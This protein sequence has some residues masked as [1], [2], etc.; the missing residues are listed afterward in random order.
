MSEA[1]DTQRILE[2][3]KP[4]PSKPAPKVRLPG[5][6]NSGGDSGSGPSDKNIRRE[7]TRGA[8]DKKPKDDRKGKGANDKQGG[9][10]QDKA[11][12]KDRKEK[13]GRNDRKPQAAAEPAKPVPKQEPKQAEPARPVGP[14]V[15]MWA[16]KGAPKIVAAPVEVVKISAAQLNER[17]QATEA[18]VQEPK[19]AKP[20]RT[21]SPKKERGSRNKDKDGKGK[22]G[23]PAKADAPTPT[24]ATGKAVAPAPAVSTATTAALPRPAADANIAAPVPAQPEAAAVNPSLV[25]AQVVSS[26]PVATDSVVPQ[27]VQP[28]VPN[29]SSPANPDDAS[30]LGLQADSIRNIWGSEGAAN[31][32]VKAAFEGGAA[33]LD[34][35]FASAGD[36]WKPSTGGVSGVVLGDPAAARFA[37]NPDG[38]QN[39][40]SELASSGFPGGAQRTI[41][42]PVP[43]QQHFMQPGVPVSRA[44]AYAQPLPYHGMR[45]MSAP[46]AQVMMRPNPA[47][48]MGQMFPPQFVQPGRVAYSVPASGSPYTQPFAPQPAVVLTGQDQK[49]SFVVHNTQNLIAQGQK[50][51]PGQPHYAPMPGGNPMMMG[52][53]LQDKELSADAPTFTMG[54]RADGDGSDAFGGQDSAANRMLARQSAVGQPGKQNF[55]HMQ[56][57]QSQM[58][59]PHGLQQQFMAQRNLFSQSGAPPQFVAS[60]MFMPPTQE[61]PGFPPQFAQ[62]QQFTSL[63]SS[64]SSAQQLPPSQIIGHDQFSHSR[65]PPQAGATLQMPRSIPQQSMADNVIGG[66][67]MPAPADTG[68]APLD[69]GSAPQPKA[70]D[71][72]SMSG[73][74]LAS[75]AL[76]SAASLPEGV[77]FSSLPGGPL[78]VGGSAPGAS[79]DKA[80]GKPGKGGNK[81]TDGS[82]RA[83]GREVEGE[84][85]PDA[86]KDDA[87]KAGPTRSA[88]N[89]RENTTSR[90]RGGRGRGGRGRGRANVDRG[91]KR[92][93]PSNAAPGAKGA[94]A[95]TPTTTTT[96]TTTTATSGRGRGGRGRGRGRGT[97]DRGRG[98]KRRTGNTGA[99]NAKASAP[100]ASA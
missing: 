72:T 36:A 55:Q 18:A 42:G 40:L 86:M 58:G 93:K 59:Q 74:G 87:Q 85:G 26:I 16:T 96:A 20:E 17:G 79:L 1:R 80:I 31:A 57:M 22:K 25:P 95:A 90:G 99:G 56:Q 45:D 37:S 41:G 11:R 54:A 76:P 51:F 52:Q 70:G 69:I 2:K 49:P 78:N 30:S 66:T 63:P 81:P 15:N 71:Y 38:S 3:K 5:A 12:G 14:P 44:M 34:G 88:G 97:T 39:P 24:A 8:K 60:A 82:Q 100:K 68:S 32:D 47:A 77:T 89:R 50:G 19:A 48:G 21:K 75:D 83:D 35:G 9:K 10:P 43:M 23:R 84:W 53:H 92:G 61:Q 4:K 13:G 98:G 91:N 64:S 28:G 46:G 65:A 7:N 33:P 94:N 67:R 73:V 62:Q 29:L 6:G 27:A